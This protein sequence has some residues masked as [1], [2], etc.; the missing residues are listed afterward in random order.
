M[1]AKFNL[2]AVDALSLIWPAGRKTAD[3][4]LLILKSEAT[5]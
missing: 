5:G 1:G 4:Q 3:I 2:P